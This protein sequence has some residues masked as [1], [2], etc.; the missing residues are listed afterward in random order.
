MFGQLRHLFKQSLIYGFGTVAARAVAFLLLPYYSHLLTP[1]EY[2]I[3]ALFMLLLTILQPFYVHGMDIAFVRFTVDA[4]RANQRRHLGAMLL[5]TLLVGGT[6]SLAL[7]VFAPGIARFV[8]ADSGELGAAITRLI[9]AIMLLD[10]FSAHIYNWLRVRNKAGAFSI[11]RIVNVLVNIGLNV[12]FIGGLEMGV[13]GAFRAFLGA[14]AVVLIVLLALAWRE[15]AHGWSAAMIREWLAFGLPNL[16]SQL[17]MIAIEFSDR[18]WIEHYLGLEEAGIYAAGYR[19][20]MLMSMIAQAFRYAWQPFF[21]ETAGDGEARRIFARVLTYYV[22]LTGWIWIACVFFL[23]ALLKLPIPGL[24]EQGAAAPLIDPRYWEGFRILPIVM[25]AHVFGGI[26]AN[27]MVGVYLKK[28]TW[29]IPVAIGGAAAVNIAGNGLLI[30][31]YGYFASA[32]LTVASYVTMTV[33]LFLYIAPRYEVPYEWRRVARTALS[34]AAF[35]GLAQPFDGAAG[36]SLRAG[37]L[38]FLPLLW[39]YYIL[40]G[41]ERSAVARRLRRG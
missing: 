21:M 27:F 20:A 31:I 22:L 39:W 41:E 23:P 6:V 5:H 13:I 11:V 1:S 7:A 8:V 14:S 30:P 25:L 15:I 40:D 35:W 32:W 9:A 19:I 37:I 3:Y 10:T 16:P 33:I 12:W 24:G 36:F 26:Y 18:K 17:F 28:K 4:G 2:G 34:V 29:I 38:L